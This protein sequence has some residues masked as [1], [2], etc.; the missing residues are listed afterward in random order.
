MRVMMKKKHNKKKNREA[1]KNKEA[2]KNRKLIRNGEKEDSENEGSSKKAILEL[3]EIYKTMPEESEPFSALIQ[4]ATDIADE[5]E[6]LR[7]FLNISNDKKA[8]KEYQIFKTLYLKIKTNQCLEYIEQLEKEDRKE[9]DQLVSQI[10]KNIF[11]EFKITLDALELVNCSK[12]IS[13][14]YTKK[15]IIHIAK[16]EDERE[17]RDPDFKRYPIQTSLISYILKQDQTEDAPLPEAED[18]SR[19]IVNSYTPKKR[20]HFR[21][22]A[23]MVKVLKCILIFLGLIG[24][25]FRATRMVILFL[26]AGYFMA[27]FVLGTL[28]CMLYLS[29]EVEEMYLCIK[30]KI[31]FLSTNKKLKQ[32]KTVKN[33][34]VAAKELSKRI[35][36]FNRKCNIIDYHSIPYTP[37]TFSTHEDYEYFVVLYLIGEKLNPILLEQG[38]SNRYNCCDHHPM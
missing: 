23:T 9:P 34:G 3:W 1:E 5:L 22:S 12:V 18:T 4:D 37:K 11:R 20:W 13:K 17:K 29:V 6:N 25:L 10:N 16:W 14:R 2:K 31:P 24:L 35:Y 38:V 19:P 33:I 36:Y 27:C 8:V 21:P 7:G 32:L 30:E 15:E 26:V 28:I